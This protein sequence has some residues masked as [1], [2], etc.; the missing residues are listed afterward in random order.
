[1]NIIFDTLNELNYTA[2]DPF[3]FTYTANDSATELEVHPFISAERESQVYLVIS[4]STLQLGHIL[5]SNFMPKLASAFRK[6]GFHTSEM[7][8][9]TTLLLECKCDNFNST[10]HHEKMKIED[11]PYYFKKYV[12]TYST[13]EQKHVDE[14]LQDI[15]NS[16]PNIFSCIEVIQNYLSDTSRFSSY[17][18]N[19]INE[20]I[21]SYFIEIATK[22]P[23]FPLPMPKACT[24]KS[25]YSILE[26]KIAT[27]PDIN[28]AAL[29]SFLALDLNYKDA[30][31]EDI[32]TGWDE[33]NSSQNI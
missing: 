1:M 32:L 10:L 7:D 11:N 27:D 17:K 28:I 30:S 6:K 8:R 20:P 3:K 16:S 26:E 22:I 2:K 24:I 31:I 12:F 15:K 5:T 9:N 18:C 4:I 33:C 25:I 29:D 23:I 14:Y 13:L 21:Y 19:S